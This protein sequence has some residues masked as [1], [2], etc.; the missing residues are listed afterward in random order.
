MSRTSWVRLLA[1]IPIALAAVSVGLSFRPVTAHACSCMAPPPAIDQLG[2]ARVAFVGTP[3][4]TS[5]V[6]PSE[7]R[8]ESQVYRFN[9]QRAVK[10]DLPASVDVYTG[11]G[12]GDCGVTFELNRPIG[13]LP[14][15]TV[16][17]GE[18]HWS[19]S[20][21]GGILSPEELLAAAEEELPAPT[22]IQPIASLVGGRYG[23]A[24]IVALD[25]DAQPVGFV[26]ADDSLSPSLLA[27]C[28]GGETALALSGYDEPAVVTID[29]RSLSITQRRALP[30]TPDES[31][32]DWYN[33]SRLTCISPDGADA[34]VFISALEYEPPAVSIVAV[35]EG[36]TAQ[37]HA[38]GRT[39]DLLT[40]STSAA[41]AVADSAVMDIDLTSGSTTTLATL[42]GQLALS[43]VADGA[44]ALTILTAS[45]REDFVY[46]V[47][48]LIRLPRSGDTTQLSATSVDPVRAYSGRLTAIPDGWLVAGLADGVGLLS[49]V[50]TIE[51]LTASTLLVSGGVLVLDFQGAPTIRGFDGTSTAI[52]VPLSNV[53]AATSV[54]DGVVPT[55]GLPSTLPLMGDTANALPVV[56]AAAPGTTEPADSSEPAD[57]PAAAAADDN[58]TLWI[59]AIALLIIIALVAAF[60][61][62]RRRR[63]HN[64]VRAADP[65]NE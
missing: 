63:R 61:V 59:V 14:Y 65:F 53:R 38:L 18:M 8:W 26:L 34:T 22:S 31:D 45:D 49:P 47:D 7:E 56:D 15:G 42:P 13:L 46:V 9:V 10:G 57:T 55:A 20:L 43:V 16:V 64:T 51:V 17:D 4:A 1:I 60:V 32:I 30:P 29:L 62:R 37:V 21:C 50:G 11:S 23:P 33:A 39:A 58:S 40:I 24:G 2:G 36:D 28:P 19:A 5:S 52:G 12:G 48:S 3:I 54:S 41:I 27:A 6:E 25:A 44:D 35:L